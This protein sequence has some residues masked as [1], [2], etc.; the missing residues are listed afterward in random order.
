MMRGL[1]FLLTMGLAAATAVAAPPPEA[2]DG[3]VLYEAMVRAKGGR[4]RLHSV[5]SL[6]VRRYYS[7]WVWADMERQRGEHRI[8]YILP[9]FLWKRE[10]HSLF[11]PGS[12]V[13]DLS[14]GIGK[15][16]SLSSKRVTYERRTD[17]TP[18]IHLQAELLIES[19]WWKPEVVNCTEEAYDK[20]PS[21]VVKVEG[22]EHTAEYFVKKGSELPWIV[23]WRE[24]EDDIL[25]AL[26]D[27]RRAGGL[28]M[29]HKY[30]QLWKKKGLP[31]SKFGFR[32]QYEINPQY[33]PRV[34]EMDPTVEGDMEPWRLKKEK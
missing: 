8:L 31:Q 23:R 25:A 32:M 26:F 2:C 10:E 7:Y 9:D 24:G 18:M 30:I 19:R 22:Q 15:T 12:Y 16:I 33:D 3:R 1:N 34:R 21:L 4:A 20:I 29:P 6:Y 5:E 11:G 13:L 14:K 28:M 17:W 27:Y